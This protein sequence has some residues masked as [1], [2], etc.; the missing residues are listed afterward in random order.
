MRYSCLLRATL[1]IHSL[2][3]GSF[4][5]PG[6]C[7]EDLDDV[8][9]DSARSVPEKISNTAISSG[10][11]L[12]TSSSA[13]KTSDSLKRSSQDLLASGSHPSSLEGFQASTRSKQPRIKT[14]LERRTEDC[15]KKTLRNFEIWSSSVSRLNLPDDKEARVKLKM[16]E[17]K[18]AISNLFQK[19]IC[20]LRA[21]PYQFQATESVLSGDLAASITSRWEAIWLK[22]I[23]EIDK[24]WDFPE[25]MNNNPSESIQFIRK[26][27]DLMMDFFIDLQQLEV[28]TKTCLSDFLNKEDGSQIVSSYVH[29]RFH[30][31]RLDVCKL[32]MNFNLKLSLLE[33]PATQRMVPLLKTLEEDSW[34]RIEF[35]FLKDQLETYLNDPVKNSHTDSTEPS[36]DIFIHYFLALVSPENINFSAETVEDFME[37]ILYYLKTAI[38]TEIAKLLPIETQ[39]LIETKLA[40][41]MI[42]FI[43]HHHKDQIANSI[44]KN[45][46]GT[47]LYQDMR[48]IEEAVGLLSSVYHSIYVRVR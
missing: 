4:Q 38:N 15:Y 7:E 14:D 10:Q 9:Q 21:Q 13:G 12:P 28:V 35:D 1:I 20:E 16:E 47:R 22:S 41:E 29:N 30:K 19:R 23:A 33:G 46:Q 39:S 26:G 37:D 24:T 18:N 31:N 45:K 3:M 2:Q 32:Y 40:R 44:M 6:P 8:A 17:V 5:A 27:I 25:L 42:A 48:A 43:I 36:M 11:G 34:K